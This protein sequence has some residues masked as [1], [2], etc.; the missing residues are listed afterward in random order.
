GFHAIGT[1]S[2]GIAFSLGLPDPGPVERDVMLAEVAR[3]AGAV[4][5]MLTGEE[6]CQKRGYAG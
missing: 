3:I 1:T 6:L 2:A 5:L 4:D